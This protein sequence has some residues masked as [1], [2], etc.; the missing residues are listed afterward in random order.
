MTTLPRLLLILWARAVTATDGSD[1]RTYPD[2]FAPPVFAST[3]SSF[4]LFATAFGVP[5]GTMLPF[6]STCTL[7]SSPP[8]IM[9]WET[10][11]WKGSF[12]ETAPTSNR[13]LCQNRA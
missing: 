5:S 11:F 8:R 4:S 9:P 12:V 2:A 10:S 3:S 1:L 7:Y 13:T 6:S